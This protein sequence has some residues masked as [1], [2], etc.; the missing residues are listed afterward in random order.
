MHYKPVICDLVSVG[1]AMVLLTPD[2]PQPLAEASA[3]RVEVAGAEANVA[4]QLAR[5]G[6]S[7]A[8]VSRVGND[9]FGV[10]IRERLAGQGVRCL[11]ET[12]PSR[13]TGVFFKDPTADGT[14]V[15]YYRDG[16]AA[17][18]M[19]AGVV[20]TLPE[21]RVV[22]LTGVTA[23]L[24]GTCAELVRTAVMERPFGREA[25]V[26]FDVNHRAGLWPAEQAAPVLARLAD[27]ADLVFVGLDEATRL[28][29]ATTPEDVRAL[30]SRAGTVIV[31]DGPVTATS[32]GDAGRVEVAAPVVDV[33]EPVG[34]GD[35]FA[36]GYLFGLLHGVPEAL[37]LGL[38]HQAAAAALG[39][40][41]DLGVLPPADELVRRAERHLEVVS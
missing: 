36:A 8:F 10:V 33:V 23:A 22:H 27:A 3:L 34:A 2:P 17:S 29:G 4:C 32:L 30:L 11:V 41:G 12:D 24:S 25:I 18:G 20:R 9:P 35:A 38:G 15:H 7:T 21:G 6:R 14:R 31:K 16:S 40:A 26:S 1:E 5:L 37:R 39:S 28:W 19:D 13:R